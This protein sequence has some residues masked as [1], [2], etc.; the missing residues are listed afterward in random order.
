MPDTADSP[1]TALVVRALVLDADDNVCVPC[2]DVPGGAVV[3]VGDRWRLRSGGNV[4][5]GHKI[6]LVAIAAGQR[7][8]KGGVPIGTATQEIAPGNHVHTWNLRSDYL[9]TYTLRDGN[10]VGGKNT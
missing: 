10:R 3:L 6:A 5:L 4:P 9:P 7:I 2:A 1:E 8:V